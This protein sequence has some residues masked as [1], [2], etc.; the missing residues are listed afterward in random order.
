MIVFRY[1]DALIPSSK[2]FSTAKRLA[3]ELKKLNAVKNYSDDRASILLPEDRHNLK[4]IQAAI[5]LKQK[6]HPQLIVVV[7]IGGSNLGTIAVQEALLG[8]NWNLHNTPRI[9]YADTVDPD[10]LQAIITEMQNVLRQGQ[11]VLINVI[12]KSGSTTET[13]A[14]FEV[15]LN[16]LRRHRKDAGKYVVA[17]TDKDSPL[18][19]LA[20][21]SGFSVL[22][23]P[24]KVGGRYSVLSAVGLFPLGM[25]GIDIK[26]LLKGAEAMKAQCLSPNIRKN[27]AAIGASL[28]YNHSKAD[29]NIYDNF[30]FSTDLESL[31]KWYRQLLAESTGK[32]KNLC[33]TP[34]VS[35]GSTDLHSMA[36][37]YLGGPNDKLTNFVITHFNNAIKVPL[38]PEYNALVPNLQ[39]KELNH[40][41]HAIVEGVKI[42][43]KKGKRP[44]TETGFD[45]KNAKALG[46][47]MQLKMIETILL[48]RLLDVNP[49]DQP[50]VELYKKETKRFLH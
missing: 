25:L 14:N 3:S 43:Y 8:K 45:G 27:P 40:V 37:L 30:L 46:A 17:T 13:V 36:Q 47:F 24:K 5:A 1:K 9:L 28:L 50:A 26:E 16:V 39:K 12:S 32:R 23:I 18:W 29:R 33:I 20:V 7:G 19:K 22:E 11:Q 38:Y 44:F 6:L 21:K 34:T 41:M 10:S 2:I 42:A 4:V 15:L 31:G 49:F 35:I 48:A